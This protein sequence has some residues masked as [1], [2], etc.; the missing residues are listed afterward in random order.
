MA[1]QE[2][3]R[4]TDS[5]AYRVYRCARVLRKHFMS[6]GAARGLEL[7]QEQWFVL[8]KLSWDDGR[9]QTELSDSLFS[10]RPNLTRILATM[11]SNG[12]VRREGDAQDQRRIRVWL[13][14]KGRRLHDSFAALV[15][16]ARSR[17]FRGLTQEEVETVTR[18]L[19]KLEQNA[20]EG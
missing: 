14:A 4:V 11:E 17:L 8:N 3:I 7:T 13:T 12:W 20:A 16:E 9:S 15:P 5:L 2:H 18:V 19:E 1:R 6:A 10:D